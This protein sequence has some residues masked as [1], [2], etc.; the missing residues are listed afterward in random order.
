MDG[1]KSWQQALAQSALEPEQLAVLA[2][3]VRDGQAVTLEEAAAM[4]DW[5]ESVIQPDEHMYGF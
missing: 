2:A 1:F 4:L 3:M 5:Q